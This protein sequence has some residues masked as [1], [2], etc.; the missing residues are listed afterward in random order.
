[1]DPKERMK[2]NDRYEVDSDE[3]EVEFSKPGSIVRLKFKNFMQYTETEFH[4]G[5]NLNTI[6][7]PNGSGKSR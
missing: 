3:D 7:G 2:I 4:C 6:V 1:M 5:P